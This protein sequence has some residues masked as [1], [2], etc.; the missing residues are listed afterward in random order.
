LIL[1]HPLPVVWARGRRRGWAQAV[2]PPL[3]VVQRPSAPPAPPHAAQEGAPQGTPGRCPL[4]EQL[5][6]RTRAASCHQKPVQAQPLAPQPPTHRPLQLGV[7]HWPR[8]PRPQGHHRQPRARERSPHRLLVAVQQPPRRCPSAGRQPRW[9][10]QQE[11]Q[12]GLPSH[13]LGWH[14]EPRLMQGGH[15]QHQQLVDVPMPQQPHPLEAY[16]AAKPPSARWAS[17]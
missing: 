13:H 1:R 8:H 2:G 10:P 17:L 15:C 16:V 9:D 7:Q 11:G 5:P 6:A 12:P 3:G 14:L 4:P